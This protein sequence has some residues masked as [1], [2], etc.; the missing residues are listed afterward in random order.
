MVYEFESL[1]NWLHAQAPKYPAGYFTGAYISDFTPADNYVFMEKV[2]DVNI[3]F[4][5]L[6]MDTYTLGRMLKTRSD[7]KSLII[8]YGGD[9][10]AQSYSDVFKALGYTPLPHNYRQEKACVPMSA[11]QDALNFSGATFRASDAFADAPFL[12][13]LLQLQDD[14]NFWL[15]TKLV[16]NDN[17]DNG[18]AT[19][20][21]LRKRRR[22]EQFF[23]LGGALFSGGYAAPH[24]GVHMTLLR[25]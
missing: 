11:L 14:L 6:L 10:H 19:L 2:E 3:T 13:A 17:D 21:T 24:L 22:T 25:P 9:F 12:P 4:M 15:T 18:G 8:F 5:G 7:Q 23:V 1:L 16:D 20:E